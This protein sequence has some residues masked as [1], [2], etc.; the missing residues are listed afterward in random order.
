MYNLI[1]WLPGYLQ[2]GGTSVVPSGR[3]VQ[4]Y[5]HDGEIEPP[6]R[7]T[8][9]KPAPRYGQTIEGELAGQGGAPNAIEGGFSPLDFVKKRLLA[10][11][12][13][14][15]LGSLAGA[16]ISGPMG[17]MIAAGDGRPD[18]SPG[19]MKAL[20]DAYAAARTHS[21]VPVGQVTSSPLPPVAGAPVDPS[22]TDIAG[23][24]QGAG[25]G[26]APQPVPLPRPRP[27]PV[28]MP[29]ARPR[30]VAPQ[31]APQAAANPVANWLSWM[32]QNAASKPVRDPVTGMFLDNRSGNAFN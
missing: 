17:A 21:S 2:S 1:P 30:A 20:T 9:Q 25:S 22:T 18:N 10:V 24:M 27:M 23:G 19:D 28:P 16:P 6:A 31:A 32:Q 7:E 5:I 4:R 14:R 15:A 13:N 12:Q 8:N 3:G 29:Q 26:Q 11:M